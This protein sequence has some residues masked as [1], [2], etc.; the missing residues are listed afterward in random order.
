MEKSI[1]LL[2]PHFLC[3]IS[4]KEE[5]PCSES[6]FYGKKGGD[7]FKINAMCFIGTRDSKKDALKSE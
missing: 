2:F 6:V 4:L 5:S 1:L 3:P 7:K